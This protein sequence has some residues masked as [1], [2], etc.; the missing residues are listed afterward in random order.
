[1]YTIEPV[2]TTPLYKTQIQISKDYKNNLENY[3]KK[4]EYVKHRSGT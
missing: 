1:M 4:V 2:F 3:F